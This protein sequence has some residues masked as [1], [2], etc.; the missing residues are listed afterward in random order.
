MATNRQLKIKQ[1]E[2]DAIKWCDSELNGDKCG[3]YDYC[4]ICDKAVEYPCARAF[5]AHRNESVITQGIEFRGNMQLSALAQRL[6]ALR[7]AKNLTIEQAA[8]KCHVS[9][10][11]LFEFENDK[12][13]PSEDELRRIL[14]VLEKR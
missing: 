2:L 3:T 5:Y 9:A 12:S 7:L 10:K 6:Q 14:L 11:K 1:D 4:V 8:R 13:N